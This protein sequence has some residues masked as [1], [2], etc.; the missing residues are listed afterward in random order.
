[1]GKDNSQGMAISNYEQK[2][3]VENGRYTYLNNI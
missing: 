3:P 1:M 2:L